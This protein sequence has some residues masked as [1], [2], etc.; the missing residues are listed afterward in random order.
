MSKFSLFSIISIAYNRLAYSEEL[1]LS[2]IQEHCQE[3]PLVK[4]FDLFF[5]LMYAQ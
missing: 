2:V 3:T 5:F 1:A 4:H